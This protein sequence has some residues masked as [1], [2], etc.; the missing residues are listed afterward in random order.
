MHASIII[1]SV[2]VCCSLC[3]A[4]SKFAM[5]SSVGTF[6]GV[7]ATSLLLRLMMMLLFLF[8]TGLFALQLNHLAFQICV[9]VVVCI[10]TGTGGICRYTVYFDPCGLFQGFVQV[11][12]VLI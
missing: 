8:S 11:K 10:L 1:S 12:K 6:L 9:V 7:R 2:S 5:F 4:P 3:M